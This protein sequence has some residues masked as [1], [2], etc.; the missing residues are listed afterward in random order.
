MFHLFRS[1]RQ[2]VRILLGAVLGLIAIS[3]VVTLIPGIYG[4]GSS[5]TTDTVLAEVRGE[6]VTL[7]EA[8]EQLQD[9][10]RNQRLPAGAFKF[11]AP[12]VVQQLITDKALLQEADRLGLGVTDEEMVDLLKLNL[13]FLFPGGTFVGKDAY[14]RFVAERFNNKSVPEFETLVRKD[15][16]MMKL[17]RLITDAVTVTPAELEKEYRRRNEKARIEYATVSEASVKSGLTASQAEIEDHFKKN[18]TAY[19]L[20]ERRT[21]QYLVI[22]DAR[23]A[24]NIQITPAEVE[25]YYNENRERFRVQDRVRV[26]HI[27]LKT[28]DKKEDE[29]KKIEARV[30]DLLKQAR[31]GKDFAELAKSNSEDTASAPKGGEVG[32]VTRGQTVPEFDAKAFS[33]KPGE[34]SDLVKTQYGFHI[35]KVLEKDNARMKPLAEVE[36]TIRQEITR[37]RAELEKLRLADRARAAAQ[38]YAQNLVQAGGEVGIPVLTGT[39]VDRN[40]ALPEV[41]AEPALMDSL[42]AATKGVVVGPVQLASKTV[43]AVVTEVQPSR[44]AELAEVMDRVKTDTIAAKAREAVE[45]RAQKLLERAQALGGDLKKAAKEF[46]AEVKTSDAFPRDGSIPGL[47][48]AS[49]VAQAF[50]A[51]AHTLAGP[52]AAG[53]DRAVYKVIERIEADM[54]G[55][56]GEKGI[57]R[58]NIAG[59]RQNEAFEVFKDELRERLKRQGK[60]KIYQDRVDRF[61]GGGRG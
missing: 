58:E 48:P 53:A 46:G 43:V 4:G 13:P 9:A 26:T 34:I 20:P 28:T 45:A 10:A 50:T 60:I 8:Q 55:F 24:T 44:Q 40:A 39:L 14:A 22:D 54:A 5:G 38:K 57:I 16:M 33:M 61:V 18:R 1:R 12:Q 19:P 17:R 36:A 37:D 21:F 47:G 11:M 31:A 35:L 51:P 30:Q 29:I 59:T 32:W 2:A 3:M 23:A 7:N 6:E 27:L 42:F 25:R 52:V 41:G 15:L 49:S 56:E